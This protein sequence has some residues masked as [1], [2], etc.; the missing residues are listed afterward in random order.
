MIRGEVV[1]GGGWRRETHGFDSLPLYVR[2]GAVIPVGARD[3]RP[4][5]DYLDG[6]T[7]DVYAASETGSTTV[8]VTTPDGVVAEFSVERSA[9]GVRAHSDLDS[10]WSVRSVGGSTEA[11]QAG[12]AEVGR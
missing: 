2:D 4:D 1:T 9:G 10:G 11:A 3:D 7:L 6:L 5:Y 12:T 8:S